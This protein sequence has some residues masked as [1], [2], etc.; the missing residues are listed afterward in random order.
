LLTS[1]SPRAGEQLVRVAYVEALLRADSVGARDVVEQAIA[2]GMAVETIYLEVLAPAMHEL[3]VMWERA[4]I[5]VAD[6]HLATAITQSVVAALANRLPRVRSTP[7][8]AAAPLVVCGCGPDDRHGL[9]SRMVVD[10]FDA[11]GWRVLDLGP[12]APADAFASVALAHGAAVVAVSTSLPEY[13]EGARAVRRELDGLAAPPL[14]VVGGQAYAGRDDRAR[15]VGADLYAPD[16]AVLL[17][18]LAA[19]GIAA[20]A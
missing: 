18:Q 5:T 1:P 17:V 16:P 9:G 7:A 19:R 2:G 3:G 13:L 6:E 10:F 20:C 14:M 4:E 8:G 11:A 15:E 12:A